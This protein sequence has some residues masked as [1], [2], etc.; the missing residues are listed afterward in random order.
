M[1]EI[2]WATLPGLDYIGSLK[3]TL[4]PKSMIQPDFPSRLT[5]AREMTKRDVV[6]EAGANVGGNSKELPKYA[7]FVH[8]FEPSPS[9]YKWLLRNTK[10]IPN[11][12]CYN[13]AVS[14]E[15]KRAQRFNVQYGSGSLFNHDVFDWKA[16]IEVDVIGI[17]DIPFE[18][19]AMLM[20]CEGAELPAFR[21]F[22]KWDMVDKVY[23]ET[24]M[25]DGRSTK[26]ETK[27]L[28]REH[29]D[30]VTEDVDPSGRFPWLV[31]R[32]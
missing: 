7:K 3:V 20:D 11:I 15:T 13:A 30:D 10:R 27:R 6:L 14:G 4:R 29:F 26:P 31:A 32:R 5:F 9:S 17:N 23:V 22:K 1:R 18:F 2:A 8:S 25:I 21:M 16:H 24:H 28:L 19:N 12:H